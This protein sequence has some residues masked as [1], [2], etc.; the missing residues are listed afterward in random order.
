MR[1]TTTWSP[2]SA[3]VS[4]ELIGH[5]GVGVAVGDAFWIGDGLAAIGI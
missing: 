5:V 1:V 2:W 3:S 4:A